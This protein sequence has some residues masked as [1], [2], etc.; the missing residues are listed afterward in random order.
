MA[1]SKKPLKIKGELMEIVE[2]ISS[3][4]AQDIVVLDV[5]NSSG[6]CDYFVICSADSSRQ[7]KAIAYE[8]IKA[9]KKN[10]IKVKHF[11]DD[12]SLRWMLVDFF[13][14]ILHIFLEEA[15]DF[16]NLENLWSNA[17]KI[18]LT[19]LLSSHPS[20]TNEK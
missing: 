15:R 19:S 7:V 2:I 18:P 11:Q 1:I 16:Y 5:S 3:K 14:I 4:K 12:P 6:L 17:K 8:A 10:K 20:K 13:D 9:C